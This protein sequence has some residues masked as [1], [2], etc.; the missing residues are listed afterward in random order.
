MV[1]KLLCSFGW[2]DWGP[3]EYESPENCTQVRIC[4]RGGHKHP[5]ERVIIHDWGSWEYIYN[6]K[7]DQKRKCRRKDG[8][9]EH[10]INHRIY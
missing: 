2:H 5:E 6:N 1:L 10:R 4:R 7:C 8:V 9:T 3:W